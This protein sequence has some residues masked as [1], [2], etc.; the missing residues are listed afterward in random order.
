[1]NAKLSDFHEKV[2]ENVGLDEPL[3]DTIQDAMDTLINSSRDDVDLEQMK[4]AYWNLSKLREGF[5]KL[6]KLEISNKKKEQL[7]LLKVLDKSVNKTSELLKMDFEYEESIGNNQEREIDSISLFR[8]AKIDAEVLIDHWAKAGIEVTSIPSHL[9]KV[10]HTL[11]M[12]F[13]ND[14]DAEIYTEDLRNSYFAIDTLIKAFSE[15]I[16]QED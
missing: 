13:G 14:E 6:E 10:R 5:K 1:M 2:K 12:L 7:E 3:S 8:N 11:V 9:E 15:A 16:F 4:D